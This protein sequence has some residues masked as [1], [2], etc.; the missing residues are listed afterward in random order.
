M[1]FSRSAIEGRDSSR[2]NDQLGHIGFT[3]WSKLRCSCE[4][5]V[6]L[7]KTL[8]RLRLT[9]RIAAS[10][11]HET[12]LTMYRRRKGS[13][14]AVATNAY[15]PNRYNID[16]ALRESNGKT[17]NYSQ[18]RQTRLLPPFVPHS[19]EG[20]VLS[21]IRKRLDAPVILDVAQKL[22]AK[23]HAL[24]PRLAGRSGRRTR[25]G[26]LSIT[27]LRG[28]TLCGGISKVTG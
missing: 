2:Y 13:N 27:S 26:S 25:S 5:P 10:P 28:P 17:L 6:R 11:S 23:P 7:E 20:S 19:L 22:T 15:S 24:I 1:T 3:R 21:P 9:E 16:P 18:Y 8:F 14:T 12:A 4:G